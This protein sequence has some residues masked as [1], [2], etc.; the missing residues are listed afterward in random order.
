VAGGSRHGGGGRKAGWIRAGPLRLVAYL[1]FVFFVALAVA[2]RT[3]SFL[4]AGVIVLAIAITTL[5]FMAARP[6]ALAFQ[7]S[8]LIQTRCPAGLCE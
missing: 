3:D 7:L 6:S 1:A 8:L 2:E 5:P 4:K